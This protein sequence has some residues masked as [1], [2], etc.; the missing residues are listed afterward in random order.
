MYNTDNPNRAISGKVSSLWNMVN[1]DPGVIS[2][3]G[4]TPGDWYIK[5]GVKYQG[6]WKYA[7]IHCTETS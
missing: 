3:G 4:Y 2:Y 1:G 5:V 6:V 7:R